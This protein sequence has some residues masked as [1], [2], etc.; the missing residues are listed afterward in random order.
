MSI[1]RKV[2]NVP[3][4]IRTFLPVSQYTII[5]DFGNL[6]TRTR[7]LRKT[8]TTILY[9]NQFGETKN[10]CNTDTNPY[11]VLEINTCTTICYS[12]FIWE[13]KNQRDTPMDGRTHI[14]PL[15]Y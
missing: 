10:H 11:I 6:K 12:T 14:V 9:S 15:I 1:L 7:I 8:S 4:Q 5:I 3:I 13:S 2:H